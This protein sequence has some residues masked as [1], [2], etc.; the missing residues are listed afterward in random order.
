MRLRLA[1]VLSCLALPA[2]AQQ[3]YEWT[4][5]QSVGPTPGETVL[6][7]AHGVPQT[8]DLQAFVTCTW[9]GDQPFADV[10]LALEIEG[11][12]DGAAVGLAVSGQGYQA[13]LP[14]FVERQDEGIWGVVVVLGMAD[15]VWTTLGGA[16]LV[17]GIPGRPSQ[18]LSLVGLEPLAAKFHADCAGIMRLTRDQAPGK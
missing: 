10:R 14:A 12:E 3:G 1:A 15:P 9:A 13:V 17:Y 4:Y 18:V 5:W 6:T 8:D 11:L 7:L 2:P 16:E